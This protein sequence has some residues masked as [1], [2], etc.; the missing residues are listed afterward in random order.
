MF[1]LQV[2]LGYS[3]VTLYYLWACSF[4]RLD[5]SLPKQI[6]RWFL[7]VFKFS[8]AVGFSGYVLLVLEIFGLGVLLH[9]FSNPA[10]ALVAVWYGLYYG[11][12]S[13]DSAEV[14]SDRIAA[15]L[16]TGRKMAVSVR[17]CGICGGELGDAM[18]AAP[19]HG[20]E[21]QPR[22]MKTVQLSCKH[23]FHEECIRGW[24]IVG[25]KDTCPTCWEKV[26]LRSLY[27]DR[28]WETSNL[29][30]IQMLDMVRY[31][32]VWNPV[33]LTGMHFAFHLVGLDHEDTSQNPAFRSPN[34]TY[35][36]HVSSNATNTTMPAFL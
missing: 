8:I 20:T 16:G 15:M 6:Y 11:I 31:L 27:A 17:D 9:P 22:G 34:N 26:D 12:L 2:W 14:A 33:I 19:S 23:L 21:Q 4:K 35:L 36:L 24:T 13:R 28:P 10:T 5:K 1:F 18:G 3:S 30:W 32:V 25:K 7:G 29:S